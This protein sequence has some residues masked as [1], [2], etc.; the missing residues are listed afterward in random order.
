MSTRVLDNLRRAEIFAGLSDDELVLVARV[1]KALRI[2][3]GRAVFKEGDPGDDLYVIH[4]GSVRV[5]IPTRGVDGEMSL[6]TINSL[7]PGQCFGE[8]VLVGG[9]LRSATVVA[10]ESATLIV[11]P[12][13]GLLALFEAHP[14]IGYLVVRNIAQDLAYKLNSSN[15]LLRGTIRWRDDEL[16]RR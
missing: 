3:E 9:T 14:H 12:A 15:L 13:P 8:I 10:A 16:G 7:Y 1:C 5:M 6:S 11:I 2:P 4:E